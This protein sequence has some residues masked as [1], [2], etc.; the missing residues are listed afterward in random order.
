MLVNFITPKVKLNEFFSLRNNVNRLFD[1]FFE[2]DRIPSVYS[3]IGLRGS[4]LEKGD[5]L[6]FTAEIP[7]VEKND[8][9]LTVQDDVITI[10]GERKSSQIP[11]EAKWVM[12]E[13]LIGEFARSFKLP[14]PV[15]Q[16]KVSAEFKEGVLTV[17]LVKSEKAKPKE[18]EVK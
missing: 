3:S 6:Q 12:N 1:D 4:L 7:G 15:N 13:R 2:T 11:D 9:K 17:N 10:K 14:Y 18:I 16:D 5:E 8:L